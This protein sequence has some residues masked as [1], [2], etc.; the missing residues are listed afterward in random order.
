[1]R[2]PLSHDVTRYYIDEFGLETRKFINSNPNGYYYL[3]GHR[4]RIKDVKNLYRLYALKNREQTRTIAE[5]WDKVIIG[6]LKGL[7]DRERADLRSDLLETTAVRRIDSNHCGRRLNKPG[8]PK[9]RLSLLV[10]LLRL[11]HY[12]QVLHLISTRRIRRSR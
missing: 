8:F 1:M 12:Y 6:Q 7:S 2:V 11:N 9:R 10:Q 3:R 4:E 5:L